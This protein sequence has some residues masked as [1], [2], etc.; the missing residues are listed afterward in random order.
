ML[1]V[2]SVYF[3]ERKFVPYVRELIYIVYV[4]VLI[5]CYIYVRVLII[6]SIYVCVLIICSFL[7]AVNLTTV[8]IVTTD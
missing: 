8:I 4:R 3:L 5:I 6:C 7:L 2:Y 1:S